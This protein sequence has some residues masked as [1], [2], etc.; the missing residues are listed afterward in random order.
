M[1]VKFS[2]KILNYFKSLLV[3]HQPAATRRITDALYLLCL[4]PTVEVSPEALIDLLCSLAVSVSSNE[5]SGDNLTFTARLLDAGM[6]KVFSL[7]WQI[8]VIKLPVVFSTF[9]DILAS[10]HGEPLLVAMEGFKSLIHTCIDENLIKQG[11]DEI[12]TSG[13]V[14]KSGPT[15]IETLC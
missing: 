14:R 9:R 8:C 5:M 1:S 2:T 4:Q 15:I 12:M 3:L 7:N 10:E 11:V 13:D 6:K